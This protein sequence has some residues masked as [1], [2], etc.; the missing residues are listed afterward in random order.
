MYADDTTLYCVRKNFDQACSQ[1]NNLLEQLLLWSSTN[2][3][4]IH[5]IKYEAMIIS[6]TGFTGPVPPI[7]FGNDFINVVNHTTCLGL[8]ID[9][10]RTW[11]MH[12]DH[13]NKSFV[14]KVGA[15]KIMKKL[16]VK[17]LEEIYFKSIAPAVT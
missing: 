9:N 3:L 12:V 13:V 6:K 15:L 11:A 5:P 8:V 1:L 4:C 10:R 2:K 17:E 7:Y 14:R 16:P